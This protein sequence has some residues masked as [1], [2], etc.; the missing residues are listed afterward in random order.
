MN[1][2][3]RTKS[4]AHDIDRQ[5]ELG[6]VVS[7]AQTDVIDR[8]LGGADDRFIN[9]SAQFF[10]NAL[11]DLGQDLVE[12]FLVTRGKGEHKAKEEKY[13]KIADVAKEAFERAAGV[14]SSFYS[15]EFAQRLKKEF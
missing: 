2:L 12:T 5:G 9:R 8:L 3:K 4:E 7:F 15:K 10:A 11:R 1:T 14:A 6:A 13:V